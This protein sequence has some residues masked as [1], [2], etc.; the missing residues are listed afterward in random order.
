MIVYKRLKHEF[1]DDVSSYSIEDI[2][3]D[4]IKL[5]LNKNVGESEYNSW[6]NSLQYMFHVLNTDEIPN[7]S[8]VAIEYNIPRSGNRIDFVLTGQDENGKDHAVLIELK[9]WTDIRL[10]NKDAIVETRFKQG[11]SEEPHPSYQV[12]SYST[13][14]NGFNEAVYSEDIKLQPCAYLHN[15][16]DN[17]VILNPFYKDYLDKAPAFLK[18]EK[19]ELQEFIKRFVRFGD[20]TDI[21]LRIE[22]GKIKPSKGLAESI[23]SMLKGN[24]EFI[25]ID[26]QKIVKEKGIELTRKSTPSKKNVYI[27]LGGPGT[28]KSVIAINLLV[29]IT[30]M[31]LLTQYVTKNSA[32]RTV[33]E[34]KLTGTFKKTEISNFFSGSGAFT[35]TKSNMYDV[36]IV[37]EAH[38]LNEKS[39]LFNNLG[40]NQVKELIN[41]SKCTIFFLDEDQRVTLSDIGSSDEIEKWAKYYNATVYKDELV[42]QFRCSGSDGYLSWLDNTLQI[43]DTA[44]FSLDR[45]EYE[46]EVIES[47]SELRDIIFEKNKE[48][49]KAR[50]V[51]GYCWDWKSKSDPEAMDIEFP[52]FDFSMKWN[53]GTD[54]MLWIVKPESVNEIGC[55]HTS[56]GLEVDYIGVIIG[57]DLIY[58]NGEIL[59]DPSKRS[60][61][62]RSIKGYKRRL[63]ESP[64]ETK[65]LLKEIIKNTY[66]TLMSR[67]MKGCYIYCTDAQTQD[68]FKSLVK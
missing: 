34:S 23:S 26:N 50:L 28:G 40:E 7:D 35:N 44:N 57:D 36:L 8:G 62:D 1:I 5:K 13:L 9:Q 56:Q 41:S 25:L 59:V 17:N 39:G 14:L 67:G 20:K 4:S 52:E 27:V 11:Y 47:P 24:D 16:I 45:N 55:I 33:Y 46:F 58:R 42:S 19:K 15:H 61:M 68:Y 18:G 63:N 3:R 51:A 6:K 54:G 48:S 30:K 32:P 12:W 10:T 65:K 29:N 38:R 43:R 31:G 53:L 49:N 21:I 37:D 66:R 60:K 2:I 64:D 22:N